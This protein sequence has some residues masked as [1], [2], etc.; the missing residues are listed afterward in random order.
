MDIKYNLV[1][2]RFGYVDN[3]EFRNLIDDLISLFGEDVI[4]DINIDEKNKKININTRRIITQNIMMDLCQ[5]I[6]VYEY[7]C[8][9]SCGALNIV[10]LEG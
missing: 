8:S 7:N 3:I 5:I 1:N 10:F 2:I 6:D 4:S 9:Y